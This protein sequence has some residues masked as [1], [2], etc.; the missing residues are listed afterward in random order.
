MPTA[1]PTTA[2]V[3]QWKSRDTIASAVATGPSTDSHFS[4]RCTGRGRP[5]STACQRATPHMRTAL[6][7]CPEGNDSP[8]RW[9]NDPG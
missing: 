8:S 1:P 6:A 9:K 4:V 5:N 2:S 3:T 7:T